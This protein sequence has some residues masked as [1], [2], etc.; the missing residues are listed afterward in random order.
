MQIVR[1]DGSYAICVGRGRQERI[2]LALVGDAPPG[3]WIL[4][5]QGTAVRT[6][7]EADAAATCAALSALEAVLAGEAN[8]DAY[9]AD[10]IE[11][12]PTLPS[13]LKES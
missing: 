13:H 10:L 11:R 9:F 7:T 1:L 4:A 3:T 2:S 12:E 5:Y 6:M 8:V